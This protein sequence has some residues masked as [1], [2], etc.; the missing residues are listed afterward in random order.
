MSCFPFITDSD[1]IA[2]LITILD[3]TYGCDIRRWLKRLAIRR[4]KA[5]RTGVYARHERTG[6]DLTNRP[7]L[8]HL[9]HVHKLTRMKERG[10]V[11]ANHHT[12][13]HTTALVCGH[14]WCTKHAIS[15]SQPDDLL[16]CVVR[17]HRPRYGRC[18]RV[19][20]SKVCKPL[21]STPIFGLILMI[22]LSLTCDIE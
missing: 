21:G 1:I 7:D 2:D 6:T 22:P 5:R 19:F 11:H 15:L 8:R 10:V 17:L 18:R 4:V 9:M 3:K 16:A 12:A 14:Y 13:G 20:R